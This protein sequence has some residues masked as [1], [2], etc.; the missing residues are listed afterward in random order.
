MCDRPRAPQWLDLEEPA[1]CELCEPIGARG[2]D[3]V[4]PLEPHPVA[5]APCSQTDPDW[6]R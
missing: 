2:P 3:D 6:P 4:I 5:A 1:P